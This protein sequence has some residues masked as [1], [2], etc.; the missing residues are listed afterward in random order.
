MNEVVKH[1]RHSKPALGIRV[2]AAI[3]EH[4][5]RR[6]FVGLVLSRDIN[7]VIALRPRKDLALIE[8]PGCDFP[9]RHTRLHNAIRML[10]RLGLNGR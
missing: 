10:L 6:R 8:R 1:D 7:A 9:L 4:H 2:S 5:E 3:H